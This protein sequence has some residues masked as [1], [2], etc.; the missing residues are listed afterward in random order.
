MARQ[1]EFGH[2]ER[3]EASVQAST[4]TPRLLLIEDDDGVARLIGRALGR[5]GYLV[6]RAV[7]GEQG[8]DVLSAYRFDLV[9]LDLMLPGM[10]GAAVLAEIMRHDPGQRVIVL[11]AVPEIGA[12]V[13]CLEAGAADFVGKPFALAELLARVRVRIRGQAP[14]PAPDS[15]VIGPVCLDLVLHRA[16]VA[17]RSVPLSH[18]EYL[19]L[20]HLMAHAGR[21]CG[22]AELLHVVWGLTFDPGSNVVD[23]CV[24][25]LRTRLD[26][27]EFIET[28]RHVG[29]RVAAA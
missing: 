29:Y 5:D 7:T 26:L 20:R 27:P 12:R 10:P 3:I 17:G 21:A 25:R 6:D 13:A 16:S 24:R 9:L 22:R 28:V 4:Y 11:S 2:H 15:L 1:E 19:L 18:R 8:L 14:G 23:V